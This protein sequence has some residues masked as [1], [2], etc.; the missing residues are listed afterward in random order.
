MNMP[1][2]YYIL[3]D[4]NWRLF[5]KKNG[6]R[7]WKWTNE[8]EWNKP[9]FLADMT[10]SVHGEDSSGNHYG[11]WVTIE[12]LTMLITRTP[13]AKERFVEEKRQQCIKHLQTYLNPE[14]RCRVGL[15][16]KCGIHKR[17]VG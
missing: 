13:E 14:C 16:W 3:K 9:W 6:P 11:T 10:M 2:W 4:T 17:W 12:P 1:R 8:T 15:H 7:V 5:F